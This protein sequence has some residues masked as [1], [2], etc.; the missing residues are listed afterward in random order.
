MALSDKELH[1]LSTPLLILKIIGDDNA[2]N[3]A[4]AFAAE[5]ALRT[6]LRPLK[7]RQLFEETLKDESDES[8]SWMAVQVLQLRATPDVL[9][10][11]REYVGSGDLRKRRRG[12][13]VLG[14]LGAGK[15]DDDRPYLDECLEIAI[16]GLTDTALQVVT[17][18]AWALTHLD[19]EKGNSALMKMKNHQDAGV[20]QAVATGASNCDTEE[21]LQTAM[22][23]MED[24]DDDVRDWATFSLGTQCEADSPEIR[25]GLRKRLDDPFVEACNEGLWGLA[26]RRDP[27]AVK[28]LL[29][30]LEQ[31]TWVSGDNVYSR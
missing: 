22:E 3:G 7:T 17:A 1:R 18:S 20:R 4:D 9:S 8:Y 24:D 11:A 6:R 15:L 5:R 12:I 19:R 25:A 10:E 27:D 14:Q 30:R 21:K 31:D 23:L 29:H 28:H 26:H 13:D 2:E 16:K